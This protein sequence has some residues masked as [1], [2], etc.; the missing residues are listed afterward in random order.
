MRRG[1]RTAEM[2]GP[3]RAGG[4]TIQTADATGVVDV[5]MIDINAACVAGFDATAAFDALF[6]NGE[7]EQTDSGDDA[8]RRSDGAESI[9]EEALTPKR[10]PN[11]DDDGQDG[12]NAVG[13]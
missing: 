8:K 5:M 12:A 2:D 1:D 3:H 9:A 7:F 6:R 4:K 13:R 11:D 10:S